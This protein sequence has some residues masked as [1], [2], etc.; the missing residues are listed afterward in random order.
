MVSF[1]FVELI[2]LFS[3][4]KIVCEYIIQEVY[5]VFKDVLFED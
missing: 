2:G 5:S 4:Y 3:V 1:N